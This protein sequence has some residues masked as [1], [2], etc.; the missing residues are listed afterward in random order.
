MNLPNRGNVSEQRRCSQPEIRFWDVDRFASTNQCVALTVLFLLLR[1]AT[2]TAE[3][4]T[5][6]LKLVDYFKTLAWELTV[7]VRAHLPG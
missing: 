6:A 7:A 1:E 3:Q 4:T 2:T 5:S